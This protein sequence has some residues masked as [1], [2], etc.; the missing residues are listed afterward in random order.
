L[1]CWFSRKYENEWTGVDQ[2][3]TVWVL[4]DAR[5]EATCEK[6]KR[7]GGPSTKPGFHKDDLEPE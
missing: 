5:M 1:C 3:R 7:K 4:P 2:G 6:K